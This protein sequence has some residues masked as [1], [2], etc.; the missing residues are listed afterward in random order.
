MYSCYNVRLMFMH[1]ACILC[2]ECNIVYVDTVH[3][4]DTCSKVLYQCSVVCSDFTIRRE[5]E[6]KRA[7]L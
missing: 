4:T 7:G 6:R 1:N 5:R 2:G 3:A